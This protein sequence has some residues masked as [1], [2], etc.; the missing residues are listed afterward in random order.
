MILI[1]GGT[2]HTATSQG[3]INN[4]DI[5]IKNGLIEQVG[6]NLDSQNVDTI[7]DASGLEITPGLIDAHNH[8]GLWETEAG[9]EGR[10]FNES[11]EPCQPQLRALDSVHW[12][13]NAFKYALSAGITTVV[14]GPSNQSIIAGQSIA[15]KTYQPE[16]NVVC[17][18]LALRINLGADPK[19]NFK[20]QLKFPS[21]RMGISSLIRENLIKAKDYLTQSAAKKK[22]DFKIQE[23]SKVL[24]DDLLV[25]FFCHRTD[26]ISTAIRL[27]DE[28]KLKAIIIGLTEGHL[29]TNYLAKKEIPVVFCPSLEGKL[30]VEQKNATHATAGILQKAGIKLA[31]A[32]NGPRPPA[33][34]LPFLLALCIRAGL[35]KDEALNTITSYPASMFGLD[36]RIGSIAKGLDAD[37]VIWG[38]TPLDYWGQ[39]QTVIINGEVVYQATAKT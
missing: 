24:T 37:L 34:L 18:Q 33:Q 9:N 2:V 21:T 6:V 32:S 28:F 15:L 19:N 29:L 30:H 20:G 23:L 8:I 4:C 26:D 36:N 31:L 27:R 17:K 11:K 22:F 1:K 5:L 14:T 13:D 16:R 25:T 3:V 39:A 12:K 38:Q 10:D 7:L 35:N